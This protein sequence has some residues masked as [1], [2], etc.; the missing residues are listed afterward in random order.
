MGYGHSDF[1]NLY[2]ENIKIS[3][4]KVYHIG[5]RDIDAGE[6]EFI[7]NTNMNMYYPEDLASKGLDSIVIDI[8]S[9]LHSKNI[10]AIHI[11]F[12]LDFIDSQYV[13]GTGTRVENGFTVDE[14]KHLLIKLLESGLVKPMDLV[15]LNPSLDKYDITADIAIDIVDTVFK[16][17]K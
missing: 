8:L 15:E 9:S 2:N 4:N 12:D 14:S 10:E 13:P 1:K 3:E 7:Q 6:K 5:D 17:L 16:N 11:S